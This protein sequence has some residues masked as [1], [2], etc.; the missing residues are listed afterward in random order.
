MEMDRI[1]N[2]AVAAQARRSAPLKS[3]VTLVLCLG[4]TW[5]SAAQAPGAA[6]FVSAQQAAMKPLAAFDGVW[7]GP[8][9]VTQPDG[10]KLQLTQTERV[11]GMLDGSI[12][13]IEGLAYDA[14]GQ[15]A[16]F[17]AFAIIS[18]APDTR[19]FN[20]RSYAQGR[21]GDFP[22]EVAP[23][24]FTWTIPAGPSA[25]IRYAAKIENGTWTE[26]GERIVE[27]QTPV[28]MFEMKLQRIGDTDW[29]SGGA[30]QFK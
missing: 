10:T 3:A 18:Y 7:R 16:G 12:K 17:N 13:V 19:K 21:A 25:T 6:A 20:F 11:G 14:A 15:P 30:V 28:R 1:E 8:A 22:L 2:N 9:V 26:I 27:G 24:A 23:N 4:A 29:P 5:V